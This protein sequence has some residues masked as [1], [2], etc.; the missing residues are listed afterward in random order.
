MSNYSLPYN[1]NSVSSINQ[2]LDKLVTM[3]NDI[4]NAYSSLMP[5]TIN[6]DDDSKT[7]NELLSNKSL[8]AHNAYMELA[9]IKN[10]LISLIRE[11]IARLLEMKIALITSKCQE[12]ISEIENSS[13]LKSLNKLYYNLS[14]I[15]DLG[16]YN[17]KYWSVFELVDKNH[18]L[19]LKNSLQIIN[20][21]YERKKTRLSKKGLS[22]GSIKRFALSLF[23]Y[24]DSRV[25]GYR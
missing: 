18:K 22:F 9:I 24:A 14:V 4:E 19:Y 10:R 25:K 6:L 12:Y 17:Y 21:S 3:I 15:L 13:D 1:L 11:N 2:Y 7:L 8:C 20:D 5:S 23:N 16:T